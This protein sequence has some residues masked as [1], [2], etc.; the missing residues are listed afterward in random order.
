MRR[1]NAVAAAVTIVAMLALTCTLG[2]LAVKQPAATFMPE[3]I[4]MP[5]S[6]M[7]DATCGPDDP[8]W[9]PNWICGVQD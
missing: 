2:Y 9:D 3:E 5:T 4:P 1:L 8:T 7:D 6:T